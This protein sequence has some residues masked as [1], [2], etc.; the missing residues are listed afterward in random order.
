MRRA[1]TRRE[2]LARSAVVA[3][4]VAAG[5][6]CA[7]A[8]DSGGGPAGGKGKGLIDA[9]VHVW[10]DD[11]ARYPLADGFKPQDIKPKTFLPED[12]LRHASGSGVD[13][14]VLIQ[15]SFY[16]FDNSYMLEAI[17][18]R[19]QTFRGTAIVDP[20]S[21]DPDAQM[22]TLAKKGVRGF[23]I[24]PGTAPAA[25][26]LDGDGYE[27]MFRCG[28]AD[29]LAV[30]PLINPRDLPALSRRCEKFP[31]TP[32]VIDHMARIGATGTIEEADVAALCGMARHK[33]VKVKVS[34]FYALGKKKPPHDDLAPLIRRLFDAF[35]P[36]RLMWASDC[37]F[38]VDDESY[39][40]G[41][42]LL[43]DRLDFLSADD[44]DRLLRRTAEETFFS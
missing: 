32:V 12:I 43:R 38:Q 44:K 19:P 35:G 31:D 16:R 18:A 40:D 26:W 20:A 6:G 2:F 23:R 34:A 3:G 33:R 7:T 27:K 5:A 15:M 25:T 10:T 42:A 13:R 36:S 17:R 4:S 39:E 29:G 14:V 11:F 9:H 8:P 1:P 21:A 28:A 37:P 24:R 22:R 41:I 30:C